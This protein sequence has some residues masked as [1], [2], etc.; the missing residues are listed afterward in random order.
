[1]KKKSN[2]SAIHMRRNCDEVSKIL[3]ASAHPQR[4]MILCYLSEGSRTVGEIEDFCGMSQSATS[5]FL[6]RMKL[7]GLIDSEKDG[8]FVRYQIEDLRVKDLISALH[9]IF[10]S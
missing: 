2:F 4:L 9:H 5:Q 10:C 6:L 1:M 3:K 7:E 8:K